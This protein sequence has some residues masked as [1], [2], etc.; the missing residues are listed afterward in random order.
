MLER[1]TTEIPIESVISIG[2]CFVI[3]VEVSSGESESGSSFERE[4][5]LVPPDGSREPF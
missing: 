3:E 1:E 2:C 5:L 4:R